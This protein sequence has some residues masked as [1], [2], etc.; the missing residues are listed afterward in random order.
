MEIN[1]EYYF[2]KQPIGLFSFVGSIK[3]QEPN[4]MSWEIYQHEREKHIYYV[5]NIIWDWNAIFWILERLKS[6]M[7]Q[8]ETHYISVDAITYFLFLRVF[9]D[10]LSNYIHFI[11]KLLNPKNSRRWPKANSFS[12]Q[13]KWLN[14]YKDDEYF[15]IYKEA[16]KEHEF[17]KKFEEIRTLR[18]NI[19]D[20]PGKRSEMR[21]HYVSGTSEVF[22]NTGNLRN[23]IGHYL[24]HTLKYID[25]LGDYFF[26]QLEKHSVNLVPI[27]KDH[28]GYDISSI[29]DKCLEIYAWYNTNQKA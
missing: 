4:L 14:K 16:L 5:L 23:E 8:R 29:G 21:R 10:S 6:Y 13:L 18:N 25:F 12:D 27:A 19:K 22:P 1:K 2:E 3:E 9:Y 7:E 26:M 20:F 11:F 15:D 28:H 17:E 24:Y